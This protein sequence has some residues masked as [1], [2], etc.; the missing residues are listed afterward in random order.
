MDFALTELEPLDELP[1]LGVATEEKAGVSRGKGSH[2]GVRTRDRL[3][4]GYPEL[5]QLAKSPRGRIPAR[6]IAE[7]ER[8]A[9]PEVQRDLAFLEQ[10][11]DDILCADA[12][13]ARD[14]LAE[15]RPTI[16]AERR[17]KHGN[18]EA[19]TRDAP[20]DLFDE[21]TTWLEPATDQKDSLGGN[22]D[23]R[24]QEAVHEDIVVRGTRGMNDEQVVNI[25]GTVVPWPRRVL[26]RSA[27][28]TR[29]LIV[30]TAP[31][32]QSSTYA[33]HQNSKAPGV[34]DQQAEVDQQA[35]LSTFHGRPTALHGIWSR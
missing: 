22:P 29:E 5:Q 25:L 34:R 28:S 30:Q 17:R 16:V 13:K 12:E 23:C 1:H 35:P 8:D 10:E 6:S 33:N 3:R 32:L 2:A 31:Y 26:S 20:F 27:P 24:K 4:A 18:G 11:R 21:E 9:V 15:H 14:L 19:T 7:I